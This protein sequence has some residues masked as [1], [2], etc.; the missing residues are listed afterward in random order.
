MVN[1]VTGAVEV[2]AGQNH[3]CAQTREGAV[4]CWG[5]NSSGNS[6]TAREINAGQRCPVVGLAGAQ[7][8]STGN[9]HNCGETMAD[10]SSTAG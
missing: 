8:L 2:G 4:L 10:A 6:E 3:S 7:R 9:N 5:Y 1:G